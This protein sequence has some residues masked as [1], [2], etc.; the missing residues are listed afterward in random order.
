MKIGQQLLLMMKL[1]AIILLATCLQMHAVGYAQNVSP[2]EKNA[3][4]E[5][6]FREINKQTGYSFL[7]SYEVLKQARPIDIVVENAPLPQVLD[8]CFANQPLTWEMEGKLIIVKPSPEQTISGV[9]KDAKGNPLQ[10]VSVMLLPLKMGTV[11]SEKGEFLF[12]NVSA[13]F[14]TL[15]FSMVRSEERRV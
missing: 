12:K 10:G 4:S 14:Y 3:P 7:Y 5:K 2:S 6:I 8:I 15:E 11:T 1:T 9:V 13:G